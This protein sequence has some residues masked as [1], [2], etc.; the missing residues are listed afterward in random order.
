MK[1]SFARLDLGAAS[2]R[3]LFRAEWVVR[4]PAKVVAR[5][6]KDGVR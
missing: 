5:P 3:S 6:L 1:D 4:Q 2:F